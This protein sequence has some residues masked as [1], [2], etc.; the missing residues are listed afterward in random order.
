MNL[1]CSVLNSPLLAAHKSPAC[2]KFDNQKHS[3]KF[4]AVATTLTPMTSLT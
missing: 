1:F 3:A 4:C 2:T